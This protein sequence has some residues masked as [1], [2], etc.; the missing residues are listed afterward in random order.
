[1]IPLAPRLDD[2]DFDRL[3]ALALERLPVLAPDWTDYN[4]H[5]PGI[6]LVEL[7]AWVADSQVYSLAR[8]RRDERIAMAGLLGIRPRGA[9]AATGMVAPAVPPA[10]H[11][12]A[13]Q[14][15]ALTAIRAAAPRLEVSETVDLLPL[16]IVAVATEQAGATVDHSAANARP[17][18]SYAPFGVP[19]HPDAA[20]VIR[21]KGNLPAQDVRLSLGVTIEGD[22]MPA[23]GLG[24]IALYHRDAGGTERPLTPILDGSMALQREGVLALPLPAA[25]PRVDPVIVLRP[26]RARALLPRILSIAVNCLPV[27]QRA[28]ITLDIP[29]WANGRAGQTLVLESTTLLESGEVVDGVD[30]RLIAP[31]RIETL[32]TGIVWQPG[33][34]DRADPDARLFDLVEDA[35]GRI[36]LRFGNGIN[37]AR[38]RAGSTLRA[39]LQLSCG[40]SSNIATGLDWALAGH[41]SN[42]RNPGPI[43]GGADPLQPDTMLDML[44][45]RL[46]DDRLLAT[47]AQIE[48]HARQLPSAFGVVRAEMVEGWEP[49]RRKPATPRTRTLVVARRPIGDEATESE[50]WTRAVRRQ[51]MPRLALGERLI[52]TA[53][54][55]VPIAIRARLGA[56]RGHDPRLV[57]EAIRAEAKAR[58]DPMRWPLGRAVS[59][60]WIEGWLRRIAGV[61]QVQEVALLDG[62][63]DPVDNGLLALGRGDLPR[64]TNIDVTVASLE[65][66][67]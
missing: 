37:G 52:V 15:T 64:L 5:D 24:G 35:A 51:I 16:E 45:D 48:A 30:W 66:A 19:S 10:A 26:V 61:A 63:G 22:G 60:L 18:A 27:A 46:R 14:G 23:A 59:S 40:A 67:R 8:H 33:N 50:A 9:V 38:P 20:L 34:P 13:E 44:R 28:T 39:D 7:L 36:R 49:G 1:M 57:A 54:R 43:Q 11:R 29:D 2:I 58:L 3:A 4:I 53:P 47:S 31:P 25:L 6:T 32:G 62:A 65:A 17:R 41:G 55:Y 12:R 21:L 56:M 42:W